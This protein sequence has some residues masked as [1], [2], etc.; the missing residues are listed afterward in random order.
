MQYVAFGCRA[1]LGVV[2]LV[3]LVS[4]LSGRRAFHEFT[5]SLRAMRV[6]PSSMATLAAVT[7]VVCEA[8]ATVLLGVPLRSTGLAGFALAAILLAVFGGAIIISLRHGNSQPCRCFGRSATPLGRLHVWRNI[9]LVFVA[10][11]G[12]ATTTLQTGTLAL[13][14]TLMAVFT[15]LIAGAIIVALDDLAYLFRPP[16]PPLCQDCMRQV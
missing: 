6:V 4:K 16:N 14:P 10:F 2:F 3:A 7:T 15:G 5:Q 12:S 1:L 13:A 9:F 11:T 8:A